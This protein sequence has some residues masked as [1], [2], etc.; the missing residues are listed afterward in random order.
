MNRKREANVTYSKKQT[1]WKVF[2]SKCNFFLHYIDRI[3]PNLTK[4]YKL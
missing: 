1:P 3:D 4:N 2:L